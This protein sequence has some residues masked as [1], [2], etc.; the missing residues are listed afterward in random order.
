MT[1]CPLCTLHD[2]DT[3]ELRAIQMCGA[4]ARRL[5]HR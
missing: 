2:L 5:A 4:C 3:D 1:K